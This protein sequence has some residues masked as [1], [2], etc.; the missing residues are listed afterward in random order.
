MIELYVL[1]TLSAMGY[2]LNKTS[3]SVSTKSNALNKNE[4]PSV[5]SI[6]SSNHFERV[7]ELERRKA[8]K[9]LE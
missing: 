3:S 5:D 9:A 1:A 2:L 6:Y 7:K 4:L 8:A